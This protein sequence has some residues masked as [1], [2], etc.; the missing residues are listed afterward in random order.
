MVSVLTME[1][2][3]LN[4]WKEDSDLLKGLNSHFYMEY[5]AADLCYSVRMGQYIQNIFWDRNII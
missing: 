5:S 4:V 3:F 2:D 1:S